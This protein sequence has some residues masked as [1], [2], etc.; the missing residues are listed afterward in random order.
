MSNGARAELEA[1]LG[2]MTSRASWAGTDSRNMSQ[3]LLSKLL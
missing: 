2:T 3:Q 1:S